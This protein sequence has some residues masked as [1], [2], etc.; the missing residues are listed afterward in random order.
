MSDITDLVA[1]L[2]ALDTE[3]AQLGPAAREAAQR[4]VAELIP[5]YGEPDMVGWYPA[6][7]AAARVSSAVDLDEALLSLAGRTDNPGVPARR[8]AAI[9]AAARAFPERY[10]PDGDR[11]DVSLRALMG[12]GILASAPAV[13]D[14]P[15]DVDASVETDTEQVL[16]T[17]AE[18]E[19]GSYAALRDRHRARFHSTLPTDVPNRAARLVDTVVDGDVDPAAAL[20]TTIC[21][22]GMKLSDARDTFLNPAKWAGCPGWCSMSPSVTRP[23]EPGVAK[24]FL[25]VVGLGCDAGDFELSVWLDFSEVIE[26][27][28]RLVLAYWMSS[29]KVQQTFTV[30]D[31]GA[32]GKVAIDEGSLAVVQ[33]G[34]HLR[35]TTTKRFRYTSEAI[36]RATF[37][38]ASGAGYAEMGE[39]FIKQA[40]GGTAHVEECD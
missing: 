32:S 38:L 16:R 14:G 23:T 40:S 5:P 24:R 35:I 21:V 28:K 6:F 30:G 26:W 29:P 19:V 20:K 9:A 13:G 12:P 27:G 36:G 22:R 2:G 39:A 11:R 25:E 33:D 7:V 18:P 31:S 10:G 8:L 3:V 4:R 1:V 15:V 37:I 17:L 34:T